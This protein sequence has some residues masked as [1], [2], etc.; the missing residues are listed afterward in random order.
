MSALR[1]VPP[2]R[3]RWMI[4]LFIGIGTVVLMRTLTYYAG[5][6]HRQITYSEFYRLLQNNPDTQEIAEARLVEDR[7]EGRL[8][9]GTGFY[10]FVPD[11]DEEILKL[12]RQN[13]DKFDV[14]PPQ[15]GFLGILIAF[16]PW[17][18]DRKSTRLNSS[19]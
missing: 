10:V 13:V 3:S 8:K 12:L 15:A 18:I 11:Q 16:S 2:Q 7:V 17:I 9:N 5:Q 4:I 6:W 14:Q 1:P 19:H